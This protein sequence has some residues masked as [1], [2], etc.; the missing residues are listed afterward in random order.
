MAIPANKV[1][2]ARRNSRRAN[3]KLSLPGI[4]ECPHCHESMLAYRVC[5]NC[6]YYGGKKVIEIKEDKK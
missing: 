6:G 5:K 4:A 2:N 3:W 1:S